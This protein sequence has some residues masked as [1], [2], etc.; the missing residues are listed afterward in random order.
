[1]RDLTHTWDLVKE[2]VEENYAI[3]QTLDCY[4]CKMFIEL[5][6]R[7]VKALPSQ[8]STLDEKQTDLREAA[9]ACV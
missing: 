6:K 9:C 2:M 8:G 5:G 7:K 4:A 1:V 3:W